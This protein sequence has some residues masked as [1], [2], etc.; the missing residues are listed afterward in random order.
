M[1][2]NIIQLEILI[3]EYHSLVEELQLLKSD[4]ERY[5]KEIEIAAVYNAIKEFAQTMLP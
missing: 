3:S 5:E 4:M 1:H 2:T